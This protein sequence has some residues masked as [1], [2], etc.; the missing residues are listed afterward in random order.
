MFKD[1]GKQ[2]DKKCVYVFTLF[3]HKGFDNN[4]S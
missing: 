2:V 3:A 4:L 1:T